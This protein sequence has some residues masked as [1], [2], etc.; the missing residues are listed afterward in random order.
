MILAASFDLDRERAEPTWGDPSHR[1][2]DR[3]DRPFTMAHLHVNN[4]DIV[5]DNE[6]ALPLGALDRLVRAGAVSAVTPAGVRQVRVTSVGAGGTSVK[7]RLRVVKGATPARTAR[8]ASSFR[9]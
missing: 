5:A 9:T 6:I 4:A 2:L 8:V 7:R 1:L 3:D